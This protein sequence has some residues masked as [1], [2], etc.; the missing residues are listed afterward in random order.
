MRVTKLVKARFLILLSVVMV[1]SLAAV[2]VAQASTPT[3]S[4]G[5][6]TFN[7]DMDT[8]ESEVAGKNLFYTV[9]GMG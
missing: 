7:A 9:E 2:A 3:P 6:Y 4:S 5:G 8:F 1:M